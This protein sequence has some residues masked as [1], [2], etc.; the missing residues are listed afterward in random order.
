MKELTEK[1]KAAHQLASHY[2]RSLLDQEIK[3]R[4]IVDWRIEEMMPQLEQI[5]NQK[6]EER[7]SSVSNK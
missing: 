2:T 4:R 6:I 7:L 1:Q 5:I 3:I